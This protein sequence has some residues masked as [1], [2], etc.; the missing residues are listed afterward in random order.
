MKTLA[1][2]YAES[3]FVLA[4]TGAAFIY[5]PAALLVGAAFFVVLAYLAD[6]RAEA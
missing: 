5:P 3:A 1:E 6:R 4:V 2:R